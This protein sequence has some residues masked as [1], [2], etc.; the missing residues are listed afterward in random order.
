[1]KL[2]QDARGTV[3][4]RTPVRQM[5]DF[6]IST[7]PSDISLRKAFQRLGRDIALTASRKEGAW[8]PSYTANAYYGQFA[9]GRSASPE[10]I[11]GLEALAAR[12]EGAKAPGFLLAARNAQV[13][14]WHDN[15]LQGAFIIGTAKQCA[16]PGC[17]I[18][19]VGSVPWRKYCPEHSP[20]KR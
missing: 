15:D 4:E 2:D 8:S 12:V 20:F 3:V 11:T 6:V 7:Y 1:M 19:F 14:T 18:M 16:F 17:S 13:Q 9:T 10:F 5:M